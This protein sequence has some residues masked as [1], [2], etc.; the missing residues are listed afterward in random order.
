MQNGIN[1]AEVKMYISVKEAK[2]KQEKMREQVVIKPLEKEIS[3]VA[4]ADLSFDKNSD[5]VQAGIVILRLPGLKVVARSAVTTEVDFTYIPGLLAFRELPPLKKAWKL[6]KIKPDVLILDG[7]GIA[8]PRRLGLATHFG[9]LMD[10]PTI[11]CAKNN[12]TGN[13]EQPR[14]EKG[15]YRYIIDDGERIGIVLRSR[16]NVNP[17][18]V[19]PGHKVSFEDSREIVMR[20]LSRYK[21]PE[22][23]RKAHALVNRLRRGETEPG[24][25]EF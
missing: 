18:F 14:S 16:T 1:S 13:F 24:Y 17:I 10:H 25:I 23:T 5:K 15:S 6:L 7:H 19:S 4:G 2:A 9:I 21:L 12:L 20:C 3:T 22:T 8:H 11:G